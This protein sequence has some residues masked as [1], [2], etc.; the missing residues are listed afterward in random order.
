VGQCGEDLAGQYLAEKG[1]EI[2]HRNFRT[3]VGEID[4]VARDKDTLV[5]V[6]VKS[7]K[8]PGWAEGP[9]ANVTPDKRRR[10]IRAARAFLANL[11]RD[12]MYCRFDVITVRGSQVEHFPGA[13]SA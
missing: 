11:G 8:G 4:L 1:F 10:V 7:F 2:L 5:F 6:E 9:L 3:K 12:D 13:F